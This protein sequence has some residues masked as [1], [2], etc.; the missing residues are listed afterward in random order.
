MKHLLLLNML[1][2]CLVAL[3]FVFTIDI[4][5]IEV[6]N[7]YSA[8]VTAVSQSV[9]ERNKALKNALKAVVIK[10]GGKEVKHPVFTQ[11]F[12]NYNQ[13][14][15]QFRYLRENDQ[16]F[17]HVSFNEKKIN[18][19]FKQSDSA[20]WGRLRPQVLVWVVEENALERNILS[21]TSFSQ[22]PDAITRFSQLRGLPLLMPLMD[23]TDLSALDLTDLW[24]R[25]SQPVAMASKRY[26]AEAVVIIRISNSSLLPEQN[27]DVSC[28]ALC[29]HQSMM[30]DWSL[31]PDVDSELSQVFSEPYYGDDALVL[32]NNAL[33]NITDVIYQQYALS[34]TNSHEFEINVANISSLE[35]LTEITEFLNELSAVESVQLTQVNGQNGIFK[36]SL[37]GSQQALLAS[38]K[39]SDQ[40]NQYIDPL[41]GPAEKNQIP[42]FYWGK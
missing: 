14:V 28:G 31:M 41:A 40:I 17:I 2:N 32:L 12:K 7:L 10:V 11:A 15:N 6:E 26:A 5:A 24:G 18:D 25:F 23:L 36:L 4:Y 30:L 20:I 22:Y 9:S 42:I 34:T 37:I 29:Q 35:K 8:K 19:L 38:L 16:L 1:R 39:L 13:F 21:A 27:E 3:L 33:A